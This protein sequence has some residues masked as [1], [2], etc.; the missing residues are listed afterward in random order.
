MTTISSTGVMAPMPAR[1]AEIRS[2]FAPTGT[3]SS[4]ASSGSSSTITTE[5]FGSLLTGLLGTDAATDDPSISTSSLA[6]VLASALAKSSANTAAGRLAGTAAP[7]G[8]DG[9]D[10]VAAATK[11]VGV[12]Y[13]WGGTDPAT[14]LDCSGFVQ[15]AYRD[16]GIE[17]DADTRFTVT[18]PLEEDA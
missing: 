17:L 7:S 3:T 8:P 11:Y 4:T 10:V 2:R 16:V 12:P 6:T 5:N 15:R 13:V 9:N 1:V 18:L 14:G